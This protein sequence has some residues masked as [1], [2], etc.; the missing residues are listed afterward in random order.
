MLI[1]QTP[2]MTEI[3][4]DNGNEFKLLNMT[5]TKTNH[6]QKSTSNVIIEQK[7]QVLDTMSH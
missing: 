3:I 2:M 1:E 7:N 6:Y 4:V 5:Y